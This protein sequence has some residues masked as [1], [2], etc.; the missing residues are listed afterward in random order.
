[1]RWGENS[2]IPQKIHPMLP[3]PLL[4]V[5]IPIREHWARRSETV[6]PSGMWSTSWLW[7]GWSLSPEAPLQIRARTPPGCGKMERS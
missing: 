6:L 2:K 7:V 1:M 3:L 4:P 5:W